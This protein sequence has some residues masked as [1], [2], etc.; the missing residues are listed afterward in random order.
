MAA[1][2]ALAGTGEVDPPLYPPYRFEDAAQA[3]QDLADRK[4][5]GKVVVT[6]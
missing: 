3:L 5:Y 6:T 4:T 1:L 2:L